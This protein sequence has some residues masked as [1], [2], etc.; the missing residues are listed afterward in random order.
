MSSLVNETPQNRLDLNDASAMLDHMLAQLSPSDI[1]ALLESALARARPPDSPFRYPSSLGEACSPNTSLTEANLTPG[2]SSSQYLLHSSFH[3]SNCKSEPP[4]N[5]VVYVSQPDP[6]KPPLHEDVS[7]PE[8]ILQQLGNLG[9]LAD[10]PNRT[11][12]RNSVPFGD[13]QLHQALA[14]VTYALLSNGYDLRLGE[15]GRNQLKHEIAKK[16]REAPNLKVRC[17]LIARVKQ[18]NIRQ[19]M[20]LAEITGLLDKALRI[21]QE[22]WKACGRRGPRR[23]CL[24]TT[25]G[26]PA[27]KVQDTFSLENCYS[28]QSVQPPVSETAQV[29]SRSTGSDPLFLDNEEVSQMAYHQ[30]STDV[31]YDSRADI[32]ASSLSQKRPPDPYIDP[33]AKLLKLA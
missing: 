28:D 1:P 31:E 19:L 20:Q 16:I 7:S 21:S 33:P 23:T 14:P 3:P 8:E 30:F 15:R 9:L 26:A 2:D 24:E 10:I 12:Q 6:I 17:S 5:V 27:E 32:F 4:N 25:R 29:F 18:A 13:S 11:S 22:Y